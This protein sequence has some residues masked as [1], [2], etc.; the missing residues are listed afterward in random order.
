MNRSVPNTASSRGA[1]RLT[2]VGLP[3]PAALALA[4]ALCG[5]VTASGVGMSNSW[6]DMSLTKA[7]C[8]Q[9]A[10]LAV[11]KAGFTDNF[12]VAGESVFADQ[13][14]YSVLFRCVP[15]K[16]LAYVVV[17]GPDSDLADQY[18][19]DVEKGFSVK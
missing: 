1:Q 8:V 4:V 15:D 14:D 3:V 10:T 7:R 2:R 11:K 16:R 13:E 9:Q 17:A 12:E 6:I 18:V 19:S 5:G